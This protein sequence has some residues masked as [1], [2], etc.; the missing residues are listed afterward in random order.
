M[1]GSTQGNRLDWV[2]SAK[3][4]W[5]RPL[6]VEIILQSAWSIWKERNNKNFR[7]ITPSTSS[8]LSRLKEDLSLL[9]YRVGD[10]NK[11]FLLSYLA[12]L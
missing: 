1:Q 6:F 3:T 9:T 2:E 8:W 7:G 12:T 11:P 4:S 10:K 5:N